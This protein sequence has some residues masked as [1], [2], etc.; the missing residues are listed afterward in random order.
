MAGCLFAHEPKMPTEATANNNDC[1][2]FMTNNIYA[3]Q[4]MNTLLFGTYSIVL[5]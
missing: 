3:W 2:I 4:P 5:Q 1:K